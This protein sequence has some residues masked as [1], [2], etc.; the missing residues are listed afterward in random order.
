MEK[1]NGALVIGWSFSKDNERDT[2]VV[3][4]GGRESKMKVVNA[5]Y[6]EDAHDIYERLTGKKNKEGGVS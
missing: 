5:F 4:Q 2:L 6:D 1:D 3:M